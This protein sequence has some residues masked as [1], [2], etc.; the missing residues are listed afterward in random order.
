MERDKAETQRLMLQ[1]KLID[2]STQWAMQQAGIAEGMRVLDIGS[3]AGDVALIA[4]DLVGPNGSVVGVDTDG[5]ILAA[6]S[7]RAG[8]AGLDNVEFVEGDC[9][10]IDLPHPFDAVVGRQV[11]LH[12]GDPMGTVQSLSQRVVSGGIVLFQEC[13]VIPGSVQSWPPLW[14]WQRTNGWLRSA[15]L[16]AGLNIG[17]GYELGT[18]LVSSDLPQPQ[19]HLFSP[20][21]GG[22]EWPGYEYMADTIKSML[23]LILASGV[24]TADEVDVDTLADRYRD[25]TVAAGAM[26]KLPDFVSAWTW[27][28]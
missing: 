19:M 12:V 26:V 13:N 24:A 16:R 20:V 18:I 6:A 25:E 1:A 9:R 28:P 10:S 14:T 7:L 17:M 4:A 3:G 21:G 8:A 27:K 22:P 11:L 23:P 15:A 5:A 2:A